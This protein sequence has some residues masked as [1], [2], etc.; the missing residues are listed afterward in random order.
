MIVDHRADWSQDVD[1][2]TVVTLA[3]AAF[4]MPSALGLVF[5]IKS[6]MKKR[7]VVLAGDHHDVAA[8]APVAAARPPARHEL[9]ASERK[10]PV[11][12]ISGF[13]GDDYFI[14]KH[15]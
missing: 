9:L 12:P 14:D 2:I 4:A 7:I 5:G 10:T 6:K 1:R 3:I 13:H 11:A 8:A 15:L